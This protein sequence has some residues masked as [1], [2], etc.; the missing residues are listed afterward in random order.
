MLWAGQ[1]G[2]QL[3]ISAPPIPIFDVG[4]FHS[5]LSCRLSGAFVDQYFS[6]DSRAPSAAGPSRSFPETPHDRK[7]TSLSRSICSGSGRT[8]VAGASRREQHLSR[9]APPGSCLSALPASGIGVL[10]DVGTQVSLDDGPRT[11]ANPTQPWPPRSPIVQQVRVRVTRPTCRRFRRSSAGARPSTRAARCASPV[12]GG[13]RDLSYAELGIAVR[14]IARGLTAL[15]VRPG[16]RVSILAG[17]R[18]EWTLADLGAL[19]AGAVVAPIYHSDSPEECR[20]VLEHAGSRVVFCEDA[21][22]L[23]KVAAGARA[24]PAAR[25]RRHVRR[26]GCGLDLARRAAPPRPGRG[27]GGT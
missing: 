1:S 23:A 11:N 7:H 20:Y 24:L 6:A 4:L 19:C 26:R 9:S 21:E 17:T 18:A 3:R 15:G 25:A 27:C 16:D 10:P 22:Q 5:L 2:D 12:T 14:E 13:W 8:E